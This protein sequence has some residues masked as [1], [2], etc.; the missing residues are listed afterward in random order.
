M[1]FDPKCD[2]IIGIGSGTLNDIGKMLAKV[3]NRQLIIVVL[4]HP[5]TVILPVP[6]PWHPPE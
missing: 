5:W 2:I 4:P 6:H 1:N 3:T